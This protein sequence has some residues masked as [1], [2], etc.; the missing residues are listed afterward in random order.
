MCHLFA[1]SSN[2]PQSIAPF[3]GDLAPFSEK[4]SPDGWGLGTLHGGA[5]TLIK[6]PRRFATALESDSAAVSRAL[7]TTG[8]TLLFHMRESSVGK[9]TTENTH[10]FRRRFIQRTYLFMHNGTVPDV[11][12]LPLSRLE[13]AGQTD[14]EHAFLWFLE[15]MP[16]VP[17]KNLARWLKGES[18]LVRRLGKFNFVLAEGDTIWAYADTALYYAERADSPAARRSPLA[19]VPRPANPAGPRRAASDAASSLSG[20]RRGGPSA[21]ARS[22]LLSTC[23]IA[24]NDRWH[25]LETGSLLVARS[26]HLV[27]IID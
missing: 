22:V 24:T 19:I 11:R 6:E 7:R 4:E 1:I 12:K 17:P 2:V 8:T 23:P 27:E 9:N 20:G 3:A 5:S 14:S 15:A 25:R 13:R 21:S 26:G 18:D 10:P 16:P